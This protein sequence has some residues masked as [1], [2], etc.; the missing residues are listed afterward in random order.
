MFSIGQQ[1]ADEHSRVCC[2]Q[3]AISDDDILTL[4]RWGCLIEE[5]YSKRHEWLTPMDMEWAQDGRTGE[6]FI[7]QAWPE[8]VQSRKS[9]ETLE[10]YELHQRGNVLITEAARKEI[11]R[12]RPAWI[13]WRYAP[14]QAASLPICLIGRQT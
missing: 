13:R 8:T 6:W 10:T 2:R 5:H 4:S 9:V 14:A 3:Q 1:H 11:D 7:V 12:S